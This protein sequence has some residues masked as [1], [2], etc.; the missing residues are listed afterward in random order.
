[1]GSECFST[2]PRIQPFVVESALFHKN[3]YPVLYN[4]NNAYFENIYS[5]LFSI[6]LPPFFA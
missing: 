2:E 6:D 4:K 5:T 3:I 1:M